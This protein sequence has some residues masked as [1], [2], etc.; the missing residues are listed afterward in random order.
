MNQATFIPADAHATYSVPKRF[1]MSGI[2]GITT[3]MAVVFGVLRIMNAQPGYYLFFGLFAVAM[4]L[5]QMGYGTVPR[6]A[7]IVTGAVFL[8]IAFVIGAAI[9]D[10]ANAAFYA[11]PMMPFFVVAGAIFGYLGG[12][13]TAGIFLLIDL[14]EPHLPGGRPRSSVQRMAAMTAKPIA[15][16]TDD[17]VIAELV[18]DAAPRNPYGER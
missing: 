15:N 18:D 7:S 6:A 3:F 16:W 2:L 8:P 12:A 4:C 17:I 14:A 13:C 10:G 11:V 1:G 9:H 5:V